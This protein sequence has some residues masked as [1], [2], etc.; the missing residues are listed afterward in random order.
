MCVYSK[1]LSRL[2]LIEFLKLQ[3]TLDVAM[4]VAKLLGSMWANFSE[5][6]CDILIA[7]LG[8]R[9]FK[10]AISTLNLLCCDEIPLPEVLHFLK[11][12]SSLDMSF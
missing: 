1:F 12:A 4:P 5:V 6:Q 9:L 11:A 2:S 8:P 10:S 3:R 7:F